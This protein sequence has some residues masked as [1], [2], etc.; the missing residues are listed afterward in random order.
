MYLIFLEVGLSLFVLASPD[1]TRMEILKWTMASSSQVW[2]EGRVWTLVTSPLL[3]VNFISLIFHGLILWLFVPVL[4]RWWGMKRFF[5]FVFWTSLIGTFVGTLVGLGLDPKAVDGTDPVEIALAMPGVIMGLDC[6]IYASIIAYGILYADQNVQF[7][8]VLPLTG[9]QLMIGIIA[10]V[11]LMI[12]FGQ[13]WAQGAAY[14]AAMI[15][16]WLMVSGRWTPKLWYLKWKQKR[17][18]RHL[19]VVRDDD[20]PKKWLN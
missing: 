14:A 20:D 5:K 17:L 12:V 13:M 1:E 11:G 8:G 2:E 9:R 4:E 3:Q 18:R 16:A 6:F 15:L 19:R 7:F 10:V